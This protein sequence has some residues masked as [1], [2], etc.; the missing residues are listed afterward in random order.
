MELRQLE[1]FIAVAEE[2]NFTRAAERVRISQSGVSAQI[3]QLERE[4]GAELFD[5]SSRIAR[6][7]PAGRAAIGPARNALAAVGTVGQAVDD[8]G[9]LVRGRLSIGMVI[10]C[11]IMPLFVAIAKFH[12]SYPGIEIAVQEANSDQLAD[13]VLGGRLD[14]AIVGTA[15]PAGDGLRASVIVSEGL[16]ALVPPGHHLAERA[17]V[18]VSDLAGEAIVAMPPGTGIRAVLDTACAAADLSPRVVV[19]ASAG[20]AVLECAARGLGIGILSAS[21]GSDHLGRLKVIPIE[22]VDVAAQLSAV[23]S[24]PASPAVDTFIPLL[25]EAFDL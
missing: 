5:R 12:T 8:L 18:T 10:G 11:T 6:L 20:D 17:C 24:T 16:V 3:R 15:G 4:L 9:G 1:Y 14:V 13:D 25:R 2:A 21:M 19:E 7:T 22:A 23:W